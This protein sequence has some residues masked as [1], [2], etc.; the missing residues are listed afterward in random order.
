ME[1]IAHDDP[2]AFAAAAG[3]WLATDPVRHTVP[4]SVL[5]SVLRGGDEPALML[6]VQDARGT[7]VAA[8]LQ[9]VGHPVILAAVPPAHAAAV[10]QAIPAVDN[11]NGPIPTLEAFGEGADVHIGRRTRLFAL[12]RLIPPADVRGQARPADKRDLDLLGAWRLAFGVD[13]GEPFASVDAARDHAERSLRLG[14]GEILW[15]VDGRPVSQATAKP[16]VAGSSRIGPVYTPPEHRGH[17]YASAV[18]AAATRWALDAGAA[19]VVLFTDLTN[20]V[21]NRIYPR[22]GFRPVH[23]EASM[24]LTRTDG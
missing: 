14:A 12:D 17:G 16:V 7:T 8:A 22:I 15:E 21:T 19:H 24:R 23:D 2:P 4:L 13:I 3:E 5:D 11:V 18:T 1:V 20:E 9:T 6:T 10:A